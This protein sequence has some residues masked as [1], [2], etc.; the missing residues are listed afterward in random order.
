MSIKNSETVV[1]EE[2]DPSTVLACAECLTAHADDY[3]AQFERERG[4]IKESANH[5]LQEIM[6][7]PADQ[8]LEQY[9]KKNGTLALSAAADHLAALPNDLLEEVKLLRALV[10][11]Y[12]CRM[13]L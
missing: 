2:L 6:P 3:Y 7:P 10:H 1:N 9:F 5:M 12:R 11:S 4:A 13:G 8:L